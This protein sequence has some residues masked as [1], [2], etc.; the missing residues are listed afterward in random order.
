MRESRP[1]VAAES[2]VLPM[3]LRFIRPRH[4]F[5]ATDGHLAHGDDDGFCCPT[6]RPLCVRV[7]FAYRI[8]GV[9][10]KLYPVRRVVRGREHVEYAAAQAEL[11]HRADR[12]FAHVPARD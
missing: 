12:F 10:E 1:P 8:D 7:E 11:S 2:V 3:S 5:F 9:A 6:D 4:E